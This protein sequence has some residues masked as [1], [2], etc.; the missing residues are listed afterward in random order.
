VA[1]ALCGQYGLTE[2]TPFGRQY[3]GTKCGFR[4]QVRILTLPDHDGRQ[5]LPAAVTAM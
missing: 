5:R 3:D 1:K 4:D 2:S